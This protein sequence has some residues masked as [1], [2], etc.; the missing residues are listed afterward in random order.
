MVTNPIPALPAA[1]T[2]MLDQVTSQKSPAGGAA[3]GGG[4]G[5]LVL[6]LVL[7]LALGLALGCESSVL[8]LDVG[9]VRVDHM[10]GEGGARH[11]CGCARGAK[12]MHAQGRTQGHTHQQSRT[13][14]E[15][16]CSRSNQSRCPGPLYCTTVRLRQWRRRFSTPVHRRR[17]QKCERFAPRRGGL[18][19][20]RSNREQQR[21]SRRR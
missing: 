7:G 6:G 9:F 10:R 20:C 3:W 14:I 8:T 19:Q 5:G 15:A 16:R 17:P 11:A 2:V 13:Q 21:Q 4:G 12:E 1:V 18:T